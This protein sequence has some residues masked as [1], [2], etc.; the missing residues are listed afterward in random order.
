MT[1]L[2]VEDDPATA[3]LVARLVSDVRP[4]I[5]VRHVTTAAE[6]IREAAATR[7]ALVLLDHRLPDGDGLQVLDALHAARPSLPIIFLTVMASPRMIVGALRAGASDYIVKNEDLPVVLPRA[8][9]DTLARTVESGEA[10]RA[11]HTQATRRNA[12]GSTT[13]EPLRA[14]VGTSVAMD[15]VRSLV[16]TAAATTAPVLIE[17]ETGTGKEVVARTIH[18]LSARRGR[19]FV[20]INCAAV[21]EALAESELFGHAR[22]AFTGAYRDKEGLFEAARG[23]TLFLDEIEDLPLPLQAKMLRVLQDLEYRPVGT[24]ATRRADV[25]IVAASNQNAAELVHERRLRPDLYYRLRVLSILVP[26]LRTRL[27][28]LPALAGHFLRRFNARHD[29]NLGPLP[30]ALL[31]RLSTATWPGNVR[32]LENTLESLCVAAEGNRRSLDAVVA[33]LPRGSVSGGPVDERSQILNA[34]EAHRWSRQAAARTLGVSRVT[35]WR[36]M[37]RLGIRGVEEQR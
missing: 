21:P 27:E 1:I 35:L 12:T 15:H 7:P 11:G 2:H 3:A 26:P 32:E 22:G 10:G 13:C 29:T 6:G 9:R 37:T 33:D 23:G 20:P 8:V 16:R 18:G 34:L 36:R 17:G 24:S 30:P 14:L 19:P 28:D 31:R 5:E 4:D 25:R